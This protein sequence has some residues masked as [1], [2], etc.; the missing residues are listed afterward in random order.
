MLPD[1][2]RRTLI[3]VPLATSGA[4]LC[5][6]ECRSLSVTAQCSSPTAKNDQVM[7]QQRSKRN[8]THRR[9]NDSRNGA[10]PAITQSMILRFTVDQ[11]SDPLTVQRLVTLPLWLFRRCAARACKVPDFSRY[12]L[13]QTPTMS[14]SRVVASSGHIACQGSSLSQPLRVS[15]SFCA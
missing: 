6:G 8:A 4:H 9:M 7:A 12:R 1:T 11:L 2:A 15:L 3:G 10:R 5:H 13:H 14:P